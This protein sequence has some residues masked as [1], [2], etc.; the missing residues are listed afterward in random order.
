MRMNSGF[1]MIWCNFTSPS[2][3][4]ISHL[5][6]TSPLLPPPS[7]DEE[8]TLHGQSGL[9]SEA[10]SHRPFMPSAIRI[11]TSTDPINTPPPPKGGEW[12]RDPFLY[13]RYWHWFIS[14]VDHYGSSADGPS[15]GEVR[16]QP[17]SC[18]FL[19]YYS[20]V[21]TNQ[22]KLRAQEEQELLNLTGEGYWA[23]SAKPDWRSDA[24]KSLTRRR[25]LH[26][27]KGVTID[28]AAL[29]K[30]TS[31]RVLRDLSQSS[32]NCSGIDWNIMTNEIV[33]TYA[34]ALNVLSK[35][36]EKH[37]WL[38]KSNQTALRDWVASIRQ[39][40]HA[41]LVPFLEYPDQSG[42][43]ATWKRDSSLFNETN[44]RCKFQYTRLVDPQ[45]GAALGPEEWSLKWAVE[46]TLGGICS[47]LVEVGLSVEGLWQAR[48][49]AKAAAMRDVP[50]LN[51]MNWQF[52]RWTQGVEELMA[53]LGWAGEWTR[54]EQKCAIDEKCYI[55]MWPF[56][57]LRFGNS[58]RT[59]AYGDGLWYGR[60]DDSPPDSRSLNLSSNNTGH[61]RSWQQDETLLWSPICV[62]ASNF[63]LLT[64]LR[65]M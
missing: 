51:S 31:S 49:N 6:V 36:L 54:C 32:T 55:P 14:S 12:K 56:I 63:S 39:Q 27:L 33:R 35:S 23:G 26:T 61:G 43:E 3:R 41:L 15:Q 22:A 37:E 18:G 52:I 25:R 10:P 44:A 59:P 47:V 58:R 8:Q 40:T 30:E 65:D 16:V 4:L 7:D 53:W 34:G 60:P 5:N 17:A 46:E 50:I 1:E 48:F 13:S 38:P 42:D 45:E 20:P 21:F 11:D 57:D 19:S 24:L 9:D 62:N 64:R 29:M 28:D 2:L